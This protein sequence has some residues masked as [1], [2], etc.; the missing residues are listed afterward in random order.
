MRQ[1]KLKK[2]KDSMFN[3]F[4]LEWVVVAVAAVFTVNITLKLAKS[5][6]EEAKFGNRLKL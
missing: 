1:K 6:V 2:N 5:A 4:S 3:M